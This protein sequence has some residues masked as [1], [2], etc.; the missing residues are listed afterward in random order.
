MITFSFKGKPLSIFGDT[1]IYDGVGYHFIETECFTLLD[2][3]AK[4]DCSCEEKELILSIYE[5]NKRNFSN[6]E[7]LFPK[8]ASNL[9]EDEV[10]LYLYGSQNDDLLIY[11]LHSYVN[12]KYP[13]G[14]YSLSVR[15]DK[16]IEMRPT[17][18]SRVLDEII[19]NDFSVVLKASIVGFEL[20][21]RHYTALLMDEDA[22]IIKIALRRYINS[23]DSNR[24]EKLL[25]TPDI[26]YDRMVLFNVPELPQYIREALCVR[27]SYYLDKMTD[28][29]LKDVLLRAY[30]KKLTPLIA[31]AP[32]IG[33]L[34]SV[35]HS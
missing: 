17:L 1:F 21:E 22:D 34:N 11:L 23:F 5:S 8:N 10:G 13:K 4:N 30:I 26:A 20:E 32:I 7:N 25:A 18:S 16:F 12:E 29:Y 33:R 24:F 27:Y 3:M 6:E 28:D 14:K 19:F 2:F 15:L 9:T 31:F 35:Y